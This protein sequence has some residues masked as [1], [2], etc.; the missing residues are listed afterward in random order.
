MIGGS[1]P[2][3]GMRLATP[4][5]RSPPRV[6]ERGLPEGCRVPVIDADTARWKET[7]FPHLIDLGDPHHVRQRLSVE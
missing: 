7:E 1:P 2:R 3:I 6:R 5:R 4:A